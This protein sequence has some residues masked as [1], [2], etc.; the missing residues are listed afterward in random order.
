M[1]VGTICA[2]IGLVSL[3]TNCAESRNER[4]FPLPAIRDEIEMPR[5]T[6]QSLDI[7]PAIRDEYEMLR[8]TRQFFDLCSHF[9]GPLRVADNVLAWRAILAHPQA[10]E[11]FKRLLQSAGIHGQ[12][13]GL[14]G[15]YFT[16]PEHIDAA[17]AAYR[18]SSKQITGGGDVMVYTEIRV[19]A[20]WIGDGSI[21]VRM[22]EGRCRTMKEAV[23]EYQRLNNN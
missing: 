10:D 21:P 22:R 20:R 14:C 11:T 9:P 2:L 5:D 13:Y 7:A 15:I 23:D 1:Q 18:A 4:D 6:E 12:L 16:D 17:L 3:G 19:I 8:D